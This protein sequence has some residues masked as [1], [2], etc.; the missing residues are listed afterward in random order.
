MREDIR[1]LAWGILFCSGSITL[2]LGHLLVIDFLPDLVGV[3]F[4]WHFLRQYS[5][6]LPH[7]MQLPRWFAL[8]YALGLILPLYEYRP[9]LAAQVHYWG[10]AL[11]M[12]CLA[13]LIG[14]CFALLGQLTRQAGRRDLAASARRLDRVLW[15][16]YPLRALLHLAGASF[17]GAAAL[18]WL[19]LNLLLAAFAA[20]CQVI[21]P[22][23]EASPDGSCA[24]RE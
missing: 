21:A 6:S 17:S 10:G 23:T 5:S 3:C 16:L 24:A 20:N 8:I 1:H 2:G 14:R 13:L 18:L 19:V 22:P 4:F 7:W 15:V 11:W 12:I 9:A